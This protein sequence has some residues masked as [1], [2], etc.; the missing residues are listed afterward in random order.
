[1]RYYLIAGETS[2][3]LHGSNLMQHLLKID[4]HAEIRFWGGDLMAAKGG[5][6]FRHYKATAFMGITDVLLNLNK[7]FKNLSDCKKDLI[8]FKPD[9]LILIDYPGF[10]LRIAK[11]R[12]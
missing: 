11:L 1:M 4:P 12:F 2:G 10:N 3:D 5:T 8:T 6:M 9:A 7:I